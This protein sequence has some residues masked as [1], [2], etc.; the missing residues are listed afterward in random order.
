VQVFF[1]GT[2]AYF[3]FDQTFAQRV[4]TTSKKHPIGEATSMNVLQKLQ[5]V[6]HT[7][8]TPSMVLVQH[9]PVTAYTVHRTNNRRMAK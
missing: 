6:A 2:H 3:H 7:L 9:P 4:R 5:H 8:Q 1:N